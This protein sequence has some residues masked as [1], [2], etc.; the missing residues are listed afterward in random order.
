[1]V[2]YKGFGELPGRQRLLLE[3]ITHRE[4]H[5]SDRGFDVG[6][7]VEAAHRSESDYVCFV[8]SA[9]EVLAPGWLGMMFEQVL[10]PGV[11][12]VGA[13][14]SWESFYTDY[15]IASRPQP[16]RLGVD[17]LA[18]ALRRRWKLSRYRADFEPFP[19]PHLRTNAFLL[20]RRRWLSLQ[21]T[22]PLRAKAAV[23]RF[24]SGRTS[25]TRQ[26][27]AD[28]LEALVVGR[29]GVA[30]DRDQWPASSTFR[31]GNQANLLVADNRTRQ[32]EQAGEEE[33][34]QLAMLAWG[35][36]PKEVEFGN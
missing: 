19:N 3:G 9:S 12:V 31:S 22:A 7:Y 16:S 18:R 29:D 20:D 24:E 25:M 36:K 13:T 21:Q 32:Y 11:G 15:E 10:R 17:G 26:L 33:K 34:L 4:I 5:V 2:V 23:W 14:G 8:N 6:S 27:L 35:S 28:G 1:M 30:H